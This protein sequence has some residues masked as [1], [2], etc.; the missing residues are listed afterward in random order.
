MIRLGAFLLVRYIV[1]VWLSFSAGFATPSTKAQGGN[2]SGA[3]LFELWVSDADAVSEY[4]DKFDILYA[5]G[6][7]LIGGRLE[8]DEE[9]R[10]D[11]ERLTDIKRRFVE[12]SDSHVLLRGGHQYVSFGRG[13]LLRAM[14]DDDVQ[15]DRDID[16]VSGGIS[17]QAIEGQAFYG[18]PRNDD[19]KM[20]DDFLFGAELDVQVLDAL[21]IGA[22][23]VRT[24]EDDD[25]TGKNQGRP[26][27]ELFGGRASFF[28]NSIDCYIEGATRIRHGQVGPRGDWEAS[29][30]ENGYAYYSALSLSLPGC[31]IVIEGKDY[32]R[33]DAPYSTPPTCDN[34]GKSL[35]KSF[36]E[37]GLSVMSTISPTR[38]LVISSAASVAEARKADEKRLAFGAKIR[39]DWPSQ[40]VLMLGGNW[41]DEKGLQGHSART[42]WGP[43]FEAAY[44]LSSRLAL[45]WK[46]Y[47]LARTD[48]LPGYI[49]EYLEVQSAMSLTLVGIGSATYS[50]TMTTEPVREFG[51]QDTWMSLQFRYT[52]GNNC[53][54]SVVFGEERGGITCSGGICHYVSPFSGIRV[55][56]IMRL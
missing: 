47:C 29:S 8:I 49:D 54:L 24:D 13:L 9:S 52:L 50:T 3:N 28:T 31:A 18:R 12:Y 48:S 7:W 40:G 23:Y 32:Y 55:E 51:N 36:D 17:W 26:R 42:F 21:T 1:V 38:D 25:E 14:E 43:T 35:N 5:N 20:R 37:R 53:D 46:G 44:H 30:K 19:T 4:L 56:A 6:N 45:E 22:G 2:I 10:W 33:F 34:D 16:G 27:E 15:L 39:R 11:K 41:A